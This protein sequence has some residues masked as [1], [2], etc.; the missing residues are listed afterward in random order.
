VRAPRSNRPSF[1]IRP[2]LFAA[3]ACAPACASSAAAPAAETG[4]AHAAP[5]SANGERE[6]AAARDKAGIAKLQ[7]VLAEKRAESGKLRKQ[8]E[9][10]QARAELTQFDESDAPNQLARSKLD[11]ARRRDALTEQQEELAQ[12]EMLYEKQDLADKTREI[13]LQRGKR[14]V[15]RAQDELAIAERE[16]AALETK[17]LPRQRAK[18]AFEVEAKTRELDEQSCESE[19][20]LLEKRLAVRSA[21][22]ELKAAEDKAAAGGKA[23]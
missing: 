3:L 15:E 19:A 16:S 6:L 9:L 7:L 12:L 4:P 21:D 18:L 22:A 1:S 10:E 2:L 14:R 23:P 8:R 17:T 11:L 5:A 20:G 13:V